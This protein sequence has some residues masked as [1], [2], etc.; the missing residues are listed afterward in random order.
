MHMY[1]TWSCGL[2]VMHHMHGHRE[3]PL[4]DNPCL[5]QN[6]SVG[7]NRTKI[8]MVTGNNLQGYIG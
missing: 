1:S 5:V 3:Q 2:H 8:I 7:L 6:T 4:W